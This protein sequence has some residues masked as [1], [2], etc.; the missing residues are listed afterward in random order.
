MIPTE[1]LHASARD[2]LVAE[3]V[4]TL[5]SLEDTGL[6]RRL[7]SIDAVDGP[8][9][10]I[11]GRELVNWCSND[12]LGLSTHPGL[13]EAAAEATAEWGVGARASRLLSGTTSWHTRLEDALAAWFGAEAAIVFP[14]GY[15]ANLGT[16]GSLLVSQDAVFVDRLAHASLLDAARATRAAFRVFRHNDPAHVQVLLSR[17]PKARRR[18]IITEG[19]FSMDGDRAPLEEL[20]GIAESHDATV[21]VDDAHGAFVLGASGR[22]TPEAAGVSHERILYMATLGKAVGCQGGFVIGPRPLIEFLQ[23]RARA[24]IYTTALAVPVVAAA[25]GALRVLREEP[26]RRERLQ[27]LAK[28]LHERLAPLQR[29]FVERTAS[30]IVPV[31]VGEARRAL[32]LAAALWERGIWAPA[33]RPP[34]VPEGT[35]RLRLSL[36]ALHTE[37]Q[38]D[39]LARALQE[40][41]PLHRPPST[42]DCPPSPIDCSIT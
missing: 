37:Q 36:T 25:C 31:V 6:L 3:C 5:R 35:A 14:S 13:A 33:I 7:T 16:L 8:R 20:I 9:V 11:D 28:R 12:V 34:T 22:G 24:F 41:F 27:A 40:L 10:W 38:I 1:A 17:A 30:H 18:F 39:A 32:G 21:Y 15:Q 4:E 26:Q 2:R 42:V 23:N 19:V 29:H